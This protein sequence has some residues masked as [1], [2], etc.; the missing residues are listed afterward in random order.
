MSERSTTTANSGS[1][2]TAN[3]ENTLQPTVR[4]MRLYKP[5]FHFTPTFPQV[6]SDEMVRISKFPLSPFLLLPDSFGDI[7]TGE[8]FSAYIAVVNGHQN[9]SFSNLSLSVRLQTSSMVID[10]FD[11]ADQS[12]QKTN[13]TANPQL[14]VMNTN[15]KLDMIV[16]H[17]L[18]ELGAYTLRVSVNYFLSNSSS[19]PKTLRKLYRFF[20]LQPLNI[21][22]HFLEVNGRFMVQCKVTNITKSP[23]FIEEMNFVP[24]LKRCSVVDVVKQVR[25]QQEQALKDFLMMLQLQPDE[26]YAFSFVITPAAEDTTITVPQTIGYPEVK[27]CTSMGEFST[28]R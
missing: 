23:M 8:K 22:S 1:G 27:W 17:S 15:D 13:V 9:L 7:Y 10:L 21:E 26:S 18:D 12:M 2:S 3:Q 20:V 11:S 6:E 14:K 4:V 24:S 25:L 5:G 16:Q 28:F 19:E